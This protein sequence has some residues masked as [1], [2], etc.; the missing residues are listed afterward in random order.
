M[1]LLQFNAS[2]LIKNIY[3]FK[4]ILLT[5]NIC[6]YIHVQIVSS[7]KK[8][9]SL[10]RQFTTAGFGTEPLFLFLFSM[11]SLT[12]LFVLRG[13]E[14]RGLLDPATSGSEEAYPK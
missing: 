13:S 4:K 2:F 11:F 6:V 5:P 8:K 3:F 7:E 14:R 9:N 12:L 10:D 1:S